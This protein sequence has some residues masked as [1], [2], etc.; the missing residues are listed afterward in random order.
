MIHLQEI[1]TFSPNSV[2]S[3]G[4]DS[5]NLKADIEYVAPDETY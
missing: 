2:T 3:D 1:I 4:T 5:A